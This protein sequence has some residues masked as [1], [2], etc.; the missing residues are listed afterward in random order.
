MNMNDQT[1]GLIRLYRK[2]AESGTCP[3]AEMLTEVAAGRAWPWQRRRLVNH[4]AQCPCCADDYRAVRNVRDDMLATLDDVADTP[5]RGL[6]PIW[7]GAAFAAAAALV[8][9]LGVAVLVDHDT[10]SPSADDTL[11][12][13]AEFEPADTR[14]DPAETLFRSDFD[15]DS[16]A[17]EG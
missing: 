7:G 10:V 2:T 1:D 13:A 5:R 15:N 6:S 14:H 11:L 17:R 3:P 12:F 16:R 4:L 9:A 8:V